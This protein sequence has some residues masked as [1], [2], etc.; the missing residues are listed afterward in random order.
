MDS[1]R[2]RCTLVTLRSVVWQHVYKMIMRLADK[3][4]L[5]TTADGL[6]LGSRP[7][8]DETI[9]YP[10]FDLMC[11][12]LFTFLVWQ[13]LEHLVLLGRRELF[14]IDLF[15]A[16][17][18]SVLLCRLKIPA[19]IL[20]CSSAQVRPCDKHNQI[21]LITFGVNVSHGQWRVSCPVGEPWRT[22]HYKDTPMSLVV[23][24]SLACVVHAV[25]WMQL[26]CVTNILW[27]HPRDLWSAEALMT[28][29]QPRVKCHDRDQLQKWMSNLRFQSLANDGVY[30][31]YTRVLVYGVAGV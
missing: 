30:V 23:L 27:R 13:Q 9:S 2:P 21:G 17:S 20:N 22:V 4:G 18:R 15:A 10:P 3:D 16:A 6:I 8:E 19:G 5:R 26:I 25:Y 28:P 11:L 31:H 1:D 29:R 14:L 7:V 12:C 24:W